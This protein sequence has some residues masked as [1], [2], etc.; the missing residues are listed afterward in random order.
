ML[1][2]LSVNNFK[3]WKSIPEMRLAPIEG[4]VATLSLSEIMD[5]YKISVMGMVKT[6]REV[7]GD[8][9]ARVVLAAAK[10]KHYAQSLLSL[11]MPGRLAG[12]LSEGAAAEVRT[13]AQMLLGIR[14]ETLT[15]SDVFVLGND[16]LLQDHRAA[17]GIRQAYS[18][19]TITAI[20][21][22]PA[23]R[24]LLVKLN[25]LLAKEGLLPVIPVDAQ[26]P[27]ELQALLDRVHH[28]HGSVRPTALLYGS[29][30]IPELLRHQIPNQITVTQ[31]ML[32]GFL[33]VMGSLMQ[34]LESDLASVF[35]TAK[36][37]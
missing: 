35:A 7:A 28:E 33:S 36:S 31:R 20:V 37:A 32:A 26:N 5:Q 1:T 34:K 12:T 25:L 27:A 11:V 18:Q 19:T 16:L 3:S 30:T 4:P 8:T 13:K 14:Q 17:A 9:V 2:Q 6:A 24:A 15:A 23:E 22:T 21:R 29:E 10:A